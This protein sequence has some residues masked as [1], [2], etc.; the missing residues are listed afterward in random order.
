M[1]DV[2]S[3][4]ARDRQPQPARRGRGGRARSSRRGR[5]RLSAGAALVRVLRAARLVRGRSRGAEAA[6][7]A[8][9]RG[10][11]HS[12]R[13]GAAQGA[14]PRLRDAG[15]QGDGGAP[16]HRAGRADRGVAADAQSHL[17]RSRLCAR[18]PDQRG[19]ARRQ[20]RSRRPP[21][22][23]RRSCRSAHDRDRA[24]S[25][26]RGT[27]RD[28][29]RGARTGRGAAPRAGQSRGRGGFGRRL[30]SRRDRHRRQPAQGAFGP[31][32]DRRRARRRRSA[33]DRGGRSRASISARR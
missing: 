8:G 21:A 17:H 9:Y 26:Q 12:R 3:R 31:P 16:Q 1:R 19:R 18:S 6:R 30:A 28:R 15:A 23:H 32:R 7:S 10:A 25:A 20:G 27:P 2:A 14:Q 5:R 22:D 4:R 11:R 33:R 13:R 24:R 29:G